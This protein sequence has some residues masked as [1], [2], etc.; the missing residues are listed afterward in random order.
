MAEQGGLRS[1]DAVQV[2][3]SCL[4]RFVGGRFSCTHELKVTTAAH[5]RKEIPIDKIPIDIG[6]GWLLLRDGDAWCAPRSRVSTIYN[7][8]DGALAFRRKLPFR[9]SASV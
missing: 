5:V 7:S 4:R 1:A 8:R 3:V 9:G 6:E 2:P